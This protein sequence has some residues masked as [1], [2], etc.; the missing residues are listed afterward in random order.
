MTAS[1]FRSNKMKGLLVILAIPF[2]PEIIVLA[3]YLIAVIIGISIWAGI[4]YGI[5]HLAGYDITVVKRKS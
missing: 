1:L 5:F 3:E 2:I 4:V